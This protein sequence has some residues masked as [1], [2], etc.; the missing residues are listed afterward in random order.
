[1]LSIWLLSDTQFGHLEVCKFT[2]AD[3]VAKLRL[4]TD[5]AEMDGAMGRAIIASHNL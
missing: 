3:G 5:P 1:M 4:W 2:R